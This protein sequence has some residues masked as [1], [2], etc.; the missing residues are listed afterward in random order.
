MLVPGQFAKH[1]PQPKQAFGDVFRR[2]L[3]SLSSH[4]AISNIDSADQKQHYVTFLSR[5]DPYIGN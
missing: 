3:Q 4:E 5:G 2:K 1:L